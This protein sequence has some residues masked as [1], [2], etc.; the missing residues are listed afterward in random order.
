MSYGLRHPE[1][2][3]VVT[4]SAPDGL[5]VGA[6]MFG[7][8]GAEVP[9]WLLPMLRL[10]DASGGP[11]FMASWAAD[12]SPDASNPRGYAWPID[13]ATGAVI[14]AV[15][16]RWRAAGPSSWLADPARADAIRRAF[17]DRIYLTVG[18]LDEAGLAPPTK[19]FSTQLTAA[20]IPNQL[21]VHAGK[22]HLDVEPLL[23]GAYRFMLAKLPPASCG[24]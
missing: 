12:W 8:G 5:D 19:L 2:I 22:K 11:G 1:L 15:A 16:D 9:A 17:S 6:Y 24:P 4:A 23:G 20:N 18:E 3:G 21:V 7:D 10:E 13:P 14:P